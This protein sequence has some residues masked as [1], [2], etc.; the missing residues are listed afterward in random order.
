MPGVSKKGRLVISKSKDAYYLNGIDPKK[1][2]YDKLISLGAQ[3]SKY[4]I[5][6]GKINDI[7]NPLAYLETAFGKDKLH[8]YADI[9]FAKPKTSQA[10]NTP[11]NF[12]IID[13]IDTNDMVITGVEKTSRALHQ[14]IRSYGGKFIQGEN[15]PAHWYIKSCPIGKQELF[16]QLQAANQSTVI[17]NNK[18]PSPK[19]NNTQRKW[20]DALLIKQDN[21][22]ILISGNVLRGKAGSN[23]RDSIKERLNQFEITLERDIGAYRVHQATLFSI[24]Q[25][26]GRQISDAK[27]QE[28]PKAQ[29][30]KLTLQ[31]EKNIIKGIPLNHPWSMKLQQVAGATLNANGE[32]VLK[33]EKNAQDILKRVIGEQEISNEALL[34]TLE[35]ISSTGALKQIA[36][37]SKELNDAEKK[38]RLE[39]MSKETQQQTL[40]LSN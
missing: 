2:W 13:D 8:K 33:E 26:L 31:V 6:L 35:P 15:A 36:D 9:S 4:G 11:S 20:E 38:T 18:Q 32:L 23:K 29:P 5:C 37:Q 3:P 34:I 14:I 25:L 1:P 39:S 17:Q 19:T 24:N 21:E 30:Q 27:I 40:E 7:P 10:T 28:K 22:D 16:T 12:K